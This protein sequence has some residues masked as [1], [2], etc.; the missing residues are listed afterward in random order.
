MIQL[1]TF[2]FAI[3]TADNKPPMLALAGHSNSDKRQELLGLLP[4]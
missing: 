3:Q 4:K 1:H 2:F